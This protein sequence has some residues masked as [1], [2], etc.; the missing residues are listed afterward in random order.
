MTTETN[1]HERPEVELP[2]LAP[3]VGEGDPL[4]PH[5]AE[6]SHFKLRIMATQHY[7]RSCGVR[8]QKFL[9]F[10]P[11]RLFVN[12]PIDNHG[13]GSFIIAHLDGNECVYSLEYVSC[14][15]FN[16]MQS[17]VLTPSLARTAVRPEWGAVAKAY[18]DVSQL[19][20][21]GRAI[22]GLNLVRDYNNTELFDLLARVPP[23]D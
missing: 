14:D 8:F 2:F 23:Q 1:E 9:Q 3:I 17:Q 22:V 21:W 20:R 5:A 13:F 16:G 4:G 11:V 18:E 12:V 7:V 15:D 19:Q 10:N 6:V